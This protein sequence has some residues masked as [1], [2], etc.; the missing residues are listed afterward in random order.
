MTSWYGSSLEL[1]HKAFIRRFVRNFKN[2]EQQQRIYNN[3]KKKINIKEMENSSIGYMLT[4][5]VSTFLS[6]GLLQVV[7]LE[8]NGDE[9]SGSLLRVPFVSTLQKKREGRKIG[10][11]EKLSSN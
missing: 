6:K 1:I 5:S 8:R 7:S 3:K 9:Y 2:L 10:Q 11:W 4:L